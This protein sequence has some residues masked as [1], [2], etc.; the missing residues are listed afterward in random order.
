MKKWLSL[1]VV[2]GLVV[3]AV[4]WPTELT[5]E[6]R[7][8]QLI[9]TVEAGFEEAS[10]KEVAST[11]SESYRDADGMSRSSIKGILFQQFRKRGPLELVFSPILVT[12][13]GDSANA[14][15]QV[16]TVEREASLLGLPT[17]ADLLHVEVELQRE[18]EGWKIISHQ[19]QTVL[20]E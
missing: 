1:I 12:V 14:S 18:E 15:F 17:D 16:A 4:M 20:A 10:I 8:Q 11:I 7:I 6:E 5:D 13:A 3:L 19:R 9:E 2:L